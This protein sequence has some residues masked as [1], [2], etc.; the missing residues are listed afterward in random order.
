MGKSTIADM[1][2]S[3]FQSADIGVHTMR[4]ETGRRRKEFS[5]RNSFIDLD[6]AGKAN[7]AVGAEASMLDRYW[8][9]MKAGIDTGQII[10]ID[11]GAGAQEL[12]LKVAGTTGL[13]GLVAARGASFWV[14]VMTTPDRESA[15]QAAE[16]V[17]DV[18]RGMPGAEVMLAINYTN[19]AQQPGLDTPQARA[20]AAILDP[21]QVLRIEIPFCG[22]QA[23]AAFADGG[24]TFHEIL[25]AS[26]EQLV[27]WCGKG[28]LSALSA[29]AHLAAWWRAIVD[30][31]SVVWPFAA[32]NG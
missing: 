17:A 14:V 24:H 5:E 9:K 7:N 31:L 29:Q 18:I 28:E 1:T 6:E 11:G 32:P 21:L 27:R 15:R 22:A 3:Y 16:L 26:P 4:I 25:R 30:Q 19:P 2:A 10:V 20:V 8:P 23:L 12:L 13:A